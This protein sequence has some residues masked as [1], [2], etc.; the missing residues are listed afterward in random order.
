MASRGEAVITTHC[1][2]RLG[3]NFAALHFIRALAK[4]YPKEMFVHWAH[5]EY[6]QQLAPVVIDLENLQLS[7]LPETDDHWNAKPIL[8]SID[9]W[10]NAGDFWERHPLKWDYGPFMVQFFHHLA[11]QMGLESPIK[12]TRDLLFDYPKLIPGKP[13]CEPFDFLIIN[14]RPKS[15]QLPAYN[16]IEFDQ[17]IAM[18]ARKYRVMTTQRGSL[19]VT[20]TE[21][22][23]LDA[24]QIGHLSQFCH[25]II[26]VATGPA[27]PTFNRWNQESV[28]HRIILSGFE[29]INLTPGTIHT[30]KI[31]MVRDILMGRGFL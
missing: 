28:K 8:A 23:G 6:L 27:W 10:K 1:A 22:F 19:K 14:S 9:I 31:G 20:C 21:D 25:S 4:K 13:P 17:I 3:D 7:A 24:T 16:G 26:M 18:L 29:T 11:A 30:N 15:S 2:L 12:T 5:R